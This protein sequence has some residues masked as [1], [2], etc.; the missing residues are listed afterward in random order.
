MRKLSKILVLVLALAMMFTMASMFTVSAA[1]PE[2]LY[3]TPNANWKSQGARFA[4]YFFGN[5]EAWVS[6][7]DS[8]GDGVYEV[9][10]P[11]DKVYPSVIFCRMNPSASANNWNNKWNQ[12]A[13][14]TVPTA[15]PNHYTVKEGTWDK[16]GGTWSTFG[17]TCTHTNLGEAATCTT[18]Q[19]C[20]DCGD[21]V[22]SALGH[23]YNTAHL[24]TRCNE[25]APFTVAGSGA[26]MNGEWAPTNTANDMTY[27]DGVYTKVYEN[28]A[29]GSYELKVVRD[30]DWGT[31]YPS[32]NKGYTVATTG[33]T[34]TV[35]LKGTVVTITV[36]A[37]HVCDFSEP[38]CTEPGKC[39]C[40]LTQGE[41]LGHNYVDGLC[42]RCNEVDP[43]SDWILVDNDTD[44]TA[45]AMVA[46]AKIY[47]KEGT[48]TVPSI[49][50]GVTIVGLG[51]VLL[52]GT[53]S[54]TMSNITLKNLHIKGG[55]A[56]RWAYAAGNLVFENVIFEAT[57]V[58]ALH[59][60]G[61]TEGATLLY[62]DC[63]IIGWAA[64]SGSPASCVFDG[65][66]VK[67]NGSYGLIRTY[68]D[69]TIENCTF[70]VSNV[71]PDDVYQDGIHAIDA[72]VTVNNCTNANGE[73]KDIIDTSDVGY[74]VLDGETIH[75]HKYDEETVEATCT[76]VGYTTYTCPC[77][78]TYIGNEVAALG[79]SYNY[80]SFIKSATCTEDAEFEIR[81][82]TCEKS[83]F[84][85]VDE[86]VDAYLEENPWFVVKALGHDLTI[87]DAVAPTCTE[88][89]LTAGESCSRCDHKVEQTVVDALG[90]SIVV[91]EAKAPTCT[92]TGLTAGEHCSV[93]DYKVEQT[94]VDAL[95][96]DF[97]EG[98]CSVCGA[99]DPE[100][101]VH[102]DT[103][104]DAKCDDCGEYFVP[105]SP[106]KLEMYQHNKKGTYYFKGSMS[107]YYFATSNM[108]DIST[109]VDVYAEE[110]EGGYNLYFMSGETKNYIYI[111]ISG[112]HTNIKY[113]ATKAVWAFDTSLGTF[114]TV[115]NGTTYCM[116]TYNNYVTISASKLSY[117]NT[118]N[119]DVSQFV[120]RPVS[121]KD[122]VCEEFTSKTTAPTCTAQGYTT[123]TCVACGVATKVDFVDALGHD[124]VDIEALAPTCTEAGYTA[125]KD[126]SR[127]SYVEGKEAV[128]ALGHKFFAGACTVCEAADPDYNAY[129]LN[130][131]QWPEF[132]K[133]T[134]ADGDILKYNDIF[135]FIMSKNSRV[136]GS[137]KTWEDFSGTLRF[138]FGG[139]T[140]TGSVPAKNALQITADGAYTIKI[141]YVAGG[142]GRYFAIMD[143]EGTVLAETT[144]ET[145]KNEK[146]YAEL[147]IPEAG[148]YYFG[149]P[150]DNNYIFQIELVKHEH[151]YGEGVVTAPTCTE[152]GYT[153]HTCTVCGHTY[154]DAEVDALGH[155][156]VV[157]E[158]VAPTCTETGLTAGEH[159]SVCDYKVEQTVV[160]ALGHKF[161]EGKCEVCDAEDPDYEA[162]VE[163][164][165]PVDEEPKDEEPKDE[166]EANFFEKIWALLLSVFDWIADF[167]KGIFKG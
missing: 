139:K 4:A 102:K 5:G 7:T 84:Y 92:E 117:V 61:I 81:C 167:F 18:P 111:E 147:V 26:H 118:S 13:D 24:C 109:A 105:A 133:E 152:V 56:Q 138:S 63:T 134:Y 9:K 120:V 154:T 29:A 41:A 91:D 148:T 108:N 71:N 55:N 45:N 129:I 64:M 124:L 22:V 137:S 52:E 77:G 67:G 66:T 40:G 110:V 53:L 47:V 90:H 142:D 141:W 73:M 130:F 23:A 19:L 15:G 131:S 159:C 144:K 125:H 2:Y 43:E 135:T 143:A 114:T 136:D 78:D 57:S 157:D 37:P 20:L 62:K 121:L 80:A 39:S 107:G 127:C 54:G 166:E 59:F 50:D 38:T 11:T 3:L 72:T 60:D 140:P 49:A 10:V 12:T 58:Y 76:T 93:C 32:A 1:Q 119:V 163:P 94:V 115:V 6:M 98:K 100:Y 132:A 87:L 164:Q 75:I 30:H 44:L 16:G 83:F 146:Y 156:I 34:V 161:A 31:A 95:G 106:F 69:A 79:H 17:S 104:L 74:V 97:V 14:L 101:H 112:T 33:S 35:T 42:S 51:D 86:E 89:G 36:E 28:V 65:C 21:P 150:G 88:T 25:Q 155:T 85:G 153:S 165:P 8:N 145:V 70:D 126:C 128:D 27:A 103:G 122:H 162:P 160:D 116:G 113:G 149:V 48:Y 99:A 158:A 96:H 82:K 123:K 46:G 151:T 68:F